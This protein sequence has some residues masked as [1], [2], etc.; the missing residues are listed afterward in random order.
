MRLINYQN[1]IR[2]AVQV[3]NEFDGTLSTTGEGILAKKM[4]ECNHTKT[5]IRYQ[6]YERL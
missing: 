4:E 1:A 3:K 6:I 2:S 5:A